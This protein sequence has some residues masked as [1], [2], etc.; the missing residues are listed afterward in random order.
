MKSFVYILEC[1]DGTFYAGVTSNLEDRLE[2]HQMGFF[3]NCY[4]FKRRPLVLRFVRE[5]D[6]IKNAFEFEKRVKRW[7]AAKKQ[8]LISGNIKELKRL[9]QCQN[10]S[11][12]SN[13]QRSSGDETAI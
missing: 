9:S 4:T 11:H 12:H 8:A 13:H 2:K 3:R 1:S 6:R 7:S 5:F 10:Q